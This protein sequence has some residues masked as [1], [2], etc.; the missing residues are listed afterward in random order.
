MSATVA[1][2]AHRA[3]DAFADALDDAVISLLTRLGGLDPATLTPGACA[4]LATTL[5][6]AANACTAAAAR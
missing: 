4:R 1:R 5:S 2:E 3:G 6:R